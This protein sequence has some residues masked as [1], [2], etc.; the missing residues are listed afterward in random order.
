MKKIISFCLWGN[1]TKYTIGALRNAE[2]AKT[3][4]PGWICRF[5]IGSS[6]SPVVT[7]QLLKTGSHV[8][9]INMEEAG[10]W[11]GMFWRFYPAGEVD[12]D[13]ML[14][15][16]T[17]S[18]LNHREKAAVDA[19]LATNSPFHIMRDHP[20]HKTEILGGM[21]GAR[22]GFLVEI[23]Q[24]IDQYQKGDFWQVDQNF[25]REHIYP[26]V[27]NIAIVHDEFFEHKPFPTQRV[28]YEFVGDVFDANDVRHP[29]YWKALVR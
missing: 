19:W 1:D 21:W 8:E 5:Y 28:N 17:D 10:D 25:L 15:R 22:G 4:Y 7:K 3:I 26:K 24:L 23:K 6:T 13:V 29:D 14:S 27:K 16:D 9:V 12:V 2:L 11:R 18:R 20:A